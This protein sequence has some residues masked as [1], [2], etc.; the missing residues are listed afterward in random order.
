[1][2]RNTVTVS[3]QVF[4]R[5]II[6]NLC[7]IFFSTNISGLF[8]SPIFFIELFK[9][10][11]MQNSTNGKGTSLRFFYTSCSENIKTIHKWYSFFNRLYPHYYHHNQ[12]IISLIRI[13]HKPQKYSSHNK[14]TNDGR[15]KETHAI[16]PQRHC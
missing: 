10:T 13:M 5:L 6:N 12:H 16:D 7:W 4:N 9:Q 8:Y 15:Q 11:F 3:S 1:M 2:F 14:K